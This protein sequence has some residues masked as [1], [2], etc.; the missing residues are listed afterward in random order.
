MYFTVIIPA[1]LKST[2]LPNKVLLPINNKPMIEH[3]YESA[4]MSGAARIIVATDHQ[5]IANWAKSLGVEMVMTDPAHQSGTTRIH[6]VVNKLNLDAKC[7]IVGVQADEPAI[8][9]KL[10]QACAE[11][12]NAY[13]YD[14]LTMV[15]AADALTNKKD[16]QDDHTVKVVLNDADEAL[17][18]SR[19]SIGGD[20]IWEHA[21]SPVMKHIGIYAYYP[22]FLEQYLSWP[23]CILEKSERL[24]QLKAL[25]HGTTIPV[26]RFLEE[27]GFGVDTEDD[28]QK[29]CEYILNQK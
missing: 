25:Y 21:N 6:E 22:Y 5:D 2:R 19:A 29:M 23:S 4:Q 27:T 28:Y 24:E 17:Y 16:W 11:K 9:P 7:P 8:N 14:S 15:T 10:I 1:R 26:I 3:V 20:Q 18:F 13:K 12:I